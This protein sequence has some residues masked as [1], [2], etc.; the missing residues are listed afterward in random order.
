MSVRLYLVTGG[1]AKDHVLNT[2]CWCL[3]GAHDAGLQGWTWSGTAAGSPD[4]LDPPPPLISTAS[5]VES[6]GPLSSSFLM[7]KIECLDTT[8][9]SQ[10]RNPAIVGFCISA[11][12]IEVSS[13][14]SHRVCR[15]D[16]LEQC[17][18]ADHLKRNPLHSDLPREKP[19]DTS[20][21]K[22]LG[23]GFFSLTT[24]RY[25]LWSQTEEGNK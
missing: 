23:T 12:V 17:H 25:S 1:R 6:F 22:L 11:S 16:G 5:L 20:P 21:L 13:P 15:E 24:S 19:L 8:G 4:C 9:L 18:W 2:A 7:C 3:C 14:V 10:L